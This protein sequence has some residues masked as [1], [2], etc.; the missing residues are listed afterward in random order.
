[1]LLIGAGHQVA[2]DWH[3]R[4]I[5]DLTVA[6]VVQLLLR[7]PV[8]AHRHPAGVHNGPAFFRLMADDGGEHAE[9]HVVQ[10]A[11]AHIGHHQ[12]KKHI[13]AGAHFGHAV[14]LARRQRGG[15]GADADVRAWQA[16]RAQ[17]FGCQHAAAALLF[18]HGF[19]RL[20][21]MERITRAC[22]G[23]HAAQIAFEQL[24]NHN[25]L[26][27]MR[28]HAR[29]MAVGVDLDPDLERHAV[30]PAKR[31]DSH[32]RICAISYYFQSTAS[33]QQGRCLLELGR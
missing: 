12:I 10:S 2:L 30:L 3:T 26:I 11:H 19:Q 4:R 31:G 32:R 8:A 16:G 9:R 5:T 27:A 25:Q 22:M 21:R 7:A 28:L 29:A 13:H 6:V 20:G 33:S 1:M 17:A 23:H 18:G 15:R 24:A 14:E